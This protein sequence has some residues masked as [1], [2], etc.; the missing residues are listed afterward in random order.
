MSPLQKGNPG[1]F[2]VCT[3]L[4][5]FA[6]K[7]GIYLFQDSMGITFTMYLSNISRFTPFRKTV[8]ELGFKAQFSMLQ[9]HAQD[10][11]PFRKEALGLGLHVLPTGV[12]TQ[13]TCVYK[14]RTHRPT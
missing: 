11:T 7:S 9:R 5:V 13:D 6:N 1:A 8:L 10:F 2:V 3:V 14:G 12:P 4:F